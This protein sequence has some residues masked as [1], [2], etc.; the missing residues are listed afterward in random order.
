MSEGARVS[1]AVKILLA[2]D[3]PADVWLIREALMRQSLQCEIEHY[4]SAEEAIRGI[5][6][7]DGEAA[8]PDLI[9]V[10]YNLPTGDGSQILAAASS[11]PHLAQ[12]P[13]AVLSSYMR[14]HEMDRIRE[15]GA[16]AF[17]AKPANL[18]EFLS[19]VGATVA[20]LLRDSPVQ[21]SL[22]QQD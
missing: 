11:N 16:A 3:N 15:L 4:T 17:I 10:D 20:R 5:E 7:C 6:R 13:K 8:A 2:E 21:R 22:E 14:P 1:Q 12:V 19:E 18:R 9:L